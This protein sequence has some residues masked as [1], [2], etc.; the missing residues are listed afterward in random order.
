MARQ[1]RALLGLYFRR[2]GPLFA[3][4]IAYS[5]LIGSMPL[6]LLTTSVA[7]CLYQVVPQI[8]N[9]L[10]WKLR[11]F[12]PE[13]V[14]KPIIYHIEAMSGHWAEVGIVG[15]VILILVSKGIFDSIGS[16]VRGV[17]GGMHLH[18]RWIHQLYSVL[19]MVVV[20]LFFI[21]VSLD[22]PLLALISA[23]T[24]IPVATQLYPRLVTL[25]SVFL[26]GS[27]L[28]LTYVMYSPVKLRMLYSAV[29]SY[30]VSIVWHLAGYAGTVFIGLFA[31]YRFVY[32]FFAGTVL[33]LVWLQVFAH[34]ILLGAIVI[35]ARSTELP[36]ARPT[37]TVDPGH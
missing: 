26:L 9:G 34:L 30:G 31:R 35:A 25:F 4:G 37:G 11:G 12:V 7:S 5:L 27:A 10:H 17:M 21:V 16:G 19:M 14:A 23:S 8:Q 24:H 15:I 22:K 18:T 1:M 13:E 33:F 28:L 32:G 6:L 2:N 3:Q 36:S 20:I 29:V